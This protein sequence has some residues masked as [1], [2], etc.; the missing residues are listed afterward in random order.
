[1]HR[2]I[3]ENLVADPE[4]EV[5]KL[6]DYCGLPFEESC[7][8]F[9]ESKRA[10]LTP[11]AEQVRQPIYSDATELWRRYERWL[12]PLKTALGDVLERYPEVPE[13]RQSA[14][15]LPLGFSRP[16]RWSSAS[17]PSQDR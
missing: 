5:R 6:L 2:V 16:I 8:K 14:P 17:P 4:R 9:Y 15:S 1:V 3:Y 7:L 12:G 10:V 13:F 11:S